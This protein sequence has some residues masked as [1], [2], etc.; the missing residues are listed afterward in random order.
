MNNEVWASAQV[1]NGRKCGL[2]GCWSLCAHAVDNCKISE[3]ITDR[4][5]RVCAKCVYE[6]VEKSLLGVH[7]PA[8][9]LL[10]R[11]YVPGAD[12]FPT[13]FVPFIDR[14]STGSDQGCGTRFSGVRGIVCGVETRLC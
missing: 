10:A 8:G 11:S 1:L 13:A 14:L 5:A 2:S 6:V 9:P 3:K 7:S 12:R 4:G